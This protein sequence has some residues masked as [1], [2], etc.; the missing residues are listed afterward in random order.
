MVDV[1]VRIDERQVQH[2]NKV[3]YQTPDKART[4]FRNALSRGMT[5]AQVQAR[6]EIRSRYDITTANIKKYEKVRTRYI[7]AGNALRGEVSFS[8]GKIPLYRFH[9]SPAVRKYTNQYAHVLYTDNPEDW[10]RYRKTA[11][12]SAADVRGSMQL[13]P[14]AFIASFNSGHIGL[15]K[16]TGGRTSEKREK[17]REY[18]GF[19]VADM[20]DYPEAREAIQVR[21]EE[22]TAKRL[23]HE[24]LRIMNGYGTR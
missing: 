18:W 20:L 24:L 1:Q 11:P 21:A 3:L 2:I 6:K 19:A 22:I 23:D 12:E 10:R 4:V 5:A 14:A 17:L 7:D 16:R 13:R 15:F 9:P 8:G